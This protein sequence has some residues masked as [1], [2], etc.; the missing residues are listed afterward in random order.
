MDLNRFTEKAREALAGAQA[1]AARLN[2]QQIDLEHVLLSL[3]DQERGLTA[4][5]LT[6]AGVSADALT[7]K[8]QRELEKVPK[9]TGPSGAA[10]NQYASGRFSKLLAH[11][12]DEAKQLKDEYISVEH[13][14]L[15]LLN[16]NG[17]AGRILKE[18]GVSRDRLLRALQDVR[19]NQRVTS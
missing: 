2:H 14:L 11:A 12:E 3:L 4:A 6:K 10:E 1:L 17:A 15:A 18:F 13:L 8:L 7:I 16:D 9:V 19:G 5:I